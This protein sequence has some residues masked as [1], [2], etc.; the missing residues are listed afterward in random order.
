MAFQPYGLI[1]TPVLHSAYPEASDSKRRE[2]ATAPFW[3]NFL[4]NYVASNYIAVNSQQP[5]DDTTKAVDVVVKYYDNTYDPIIVVLLECKRHGSRS[6]GK[7]KSFSELEDME[8]QLEG[9]LQFFFE[10][11][12]GLA[13]R[14]LVY[15]AVAYGTR[16]RV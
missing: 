7:T 1:T 9:Y 10:R 6:K 4:N 13:K 12:G 8:S 3:E 15:G 5:P 14:P 11:D 2:S 16:I